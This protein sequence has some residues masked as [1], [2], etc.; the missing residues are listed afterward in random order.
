VQHINVNTIINEMTNLLQ[1]S[2]GKHILLRLNLAPS[3]PLVQADATQVRQVVMNLIINAAE[4]IGDKEGAVS[5]AT[6][7]ARMSREA[8]ADTQLAPDLPE[9]D[10]L[11]IEVTDTGSGM[12]EQTRARIFDPFFSTKFTGRGLGLASVLGI[13]RGHQ[14]AIKVASA[15]GQ[16]STF[17]ILLPCRPKQEAE[18]R[19]A[20]ALP[21]LHGTVLVVE[22]DAALRSLYVRML[23]S[24]GVNPL[25]A[26][27]GEQG[28][29]VL[30]TQDTDVAAVLL[31]T[32]APGL[33]GEET[34]SAMCRVK[35]DLGVILMSAYD[36]RQAVD[37][38]GDR[39]LT[40]FLQKPF[41]PWELHR[42]LSS[43]LGTS[44]AS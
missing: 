8:L 36:Q 19:A 26:A 29:E 22:N 41:T 4:A 38:F 13:V 16:G 24:M 42:Q 9:G 21:R 5:L 32:T 15:P 40:R 10:Y 28:I 20:E 27:N 11:F 23:E 33:S 44:P 30:L 2:I 43:L 31:H 1:V 34:Y 35:P 39:K 25:P 18:T 6:G 37:R 17:R 7:V 14:G 3:L 12:D